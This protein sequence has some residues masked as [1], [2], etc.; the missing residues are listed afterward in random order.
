M[1][2]VGCGVKKLNKERNHILSRIWTQD[3]E[4]HESHIFDLRREHIGPFEYHISRSLGFG[5]MGWGWIRNPYLDLRTWFGEP[6]LI[7]TLNSKKRFNMNART[8]TGKRWHD[9][10]Q[11]N[12]HKARKVNAK[13]NT[14]SRTSVNGNKN[15]VRKILPETVSQK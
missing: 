10:I 7:W 15:K 8:P 6:E 1:N 4:K 2:D 12:L 13:K 5:I 9:R 14:W 11:Q 3:D